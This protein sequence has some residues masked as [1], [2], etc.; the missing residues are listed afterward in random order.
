MKQYELDKPDN[1][2][3]MFEQTIARYADRK[4][5]G[6]KNSDKTGYDWVTYREAADR[7]DACRAGLASLGIKKGDAVGIIDNN[8]VAWA[9]SCYATYGLAA[10][11]IPM[12]KA[13]LEKVWRYIIIDSDIKVLIVSD[14]GI[15]DK[16]KSWVDEIDNL[17]QIILIDGEGPGTLSELEKKGKEN[18]VK[19]IYP[20]PDDI[21]G[22]I[23]T[24]VLQRHSCHI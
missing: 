4:W 10:R 12:Y 14:Q 18:P 16:V 23:Y 22:L 15:L 8:S 2:V 24:S 9:V 11:F 17:E 13:E 5:L 19:A 21:A 1:L 6:Y 7:V 20:D 3:E